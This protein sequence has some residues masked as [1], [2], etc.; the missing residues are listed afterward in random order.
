MKVVAAPAMKAAPAARTAHEGVPGVNVRI[1]YE[2]AG[3]TLGHFTCRPSDA[4]WGV[5]NYIGDSHHVVFPS[6]CVEIE[7]ERRKPLLADPNVMVLYDPGTIYRRRRRSPAGDVSTF[8]MLSRE[9]FREATHDLVPLGEE[10]RFPIAFS[11]SAPR[12]YL[13]ARL[14]DEALRREPIEDRLLVDELC[15]YLVAAAVRDTAVFLGLRRRTAPSPQHEDLA[16]AARRV[17]N[18]TVDQT[19]TLADIGRRLAAS[20]YHLARVFRSCTGTSLHAYRDSL[21]VR[22][23]LGPAFRRHQRLYEV[24]SRLGYS[25]ASHYSHAFRRVLGGITPREARNLCEE[26]YRLACLAQSEP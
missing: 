25:S 14:L 8:L 21:R 12:T 4:L 17:V 19:L 16:E 20:P 7:Q 3:M 1:L 24:A 22:Y 18:E 13:L 5:D 9:L 26:P 23:S 2:G 15:T 11:P 6:T 10:D